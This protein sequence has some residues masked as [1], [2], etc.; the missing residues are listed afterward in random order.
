MREG[1]PKLRSGEWWTSKGDPIARTKNRAS[2][3]ANYC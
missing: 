2:T 1:Y 3:P